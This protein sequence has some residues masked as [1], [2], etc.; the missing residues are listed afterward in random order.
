MA[1]A[2]GNDGYSSLA[3]NTPAVTAACR[4]PGAR[5]NAATTPRQNGVRGVRRYRRTVPKRRTPHEVFA[6]FEEARKSA[7]G[8]S[9]ARKHHLVPASY[10]RRWEEDGQLR[11]TVI[12]EDR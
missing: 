10:L 2:I 11:V 1:V 6:V 4:L 5:R 7:Q 8:G 9:A 12:D 3:S